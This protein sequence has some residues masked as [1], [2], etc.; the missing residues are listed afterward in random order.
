MQSILFCLL[1]IGL[2]FYVSQESYWSQQPF[3]LCRKE[4]NQPTLVVHW[5]PRCI[6]NVEAFSTGFGFQRGELMFDCWVVFFVCLFD[7]MDGGAKASCII[8]LFLVDYCKLLYPERRSQSPTCQTR[9][10]YSCG[11][12][13]CRNSRTW[14]IETVWYIVEYYRTCHTIV[15]ITCIHD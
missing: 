14:A 1:S 5:P 2:S 8:Q 7:W 13:R 9:W 4:E 10:T 11:Y 15:V 12:V 3:S 6:W